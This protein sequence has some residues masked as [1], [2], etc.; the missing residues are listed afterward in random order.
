M[1]STSA[2][3]GFW[4]T[5]FIP[6]IS[7][8]CSKSRTL[9]DRGSS[10]TCFPSLC[11]SSWC[12]LDFSLSVRLTCPTTMSIATRLSRRAGIIISTSTF[13]V[14]Y[15]SVFG[16]EFLPAIFRCGS[17]HF[18]KFGFTNDIHC[19]MHPSISRPRSLTSRVTC[20]VLESA[21]KPRSGLP[22][23]NIL[24]RARQTSASA[25]ANILRSNRSSTR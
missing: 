21:W 1:K 11:N 13:Q 9:S 23:R 15:P 7:L 10:S 25:S 5:V 4:M 8:V 18:S 16:K 3:I 24:L 22:G 20:L 14:F 6:M 2:V 12:F 19:L 17:T